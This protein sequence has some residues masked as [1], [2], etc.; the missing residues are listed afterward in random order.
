MNN[1]Q[2]LAH[3][4]WDCTYHIVWTP[5]LRRKVV[6]G[7]CGMEGKEVLAQLE[8]AKEGLGILE[9][10]EETSAAWAADR[11]AAR[12]A[13][14]PLK[15]AAGGAE[16]QYS[17]IWMAVPNRATGDTDKTITHLLSLLTLATPLL[18]STSIIYLLSKP[19]GNCLDYSSCHLVFRH[20]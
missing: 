1:N 8:E 13:R 3:A 15:R 20:L 5:K 12:A 2:G 14:A 11:W 19:Y 9:I 10:V 17:S 16:G 18:E 7:K 4:K 6:Y